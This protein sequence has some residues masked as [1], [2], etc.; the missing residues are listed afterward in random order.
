ME[1]A[2]ARKAQAEE[3]RKHAVSWCCDS[4]VA[5]STVGNKECQDELH[6]VGTGGTL[7]VTPDRCSLIYVSHVIM[8]LPLD[9]GPHD[10]TLTLKVVAGSCCCCCCCCCCRC[11][12]PRAPASGAPLPP[13]P[14]RTTAAGTTHPSHSRGTSLALVLAVTS[15]WTTG[16]P[17]SSAA[18]APGAPR[19]QPLA[20]ATSRRMS[21]LHGLMLPS[22]RVQVNTYVPE[23]AW[24]GEGTPPGQ[25]S[26]AAVT[27]SSNPGQSVSAPKQAMLW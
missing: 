4:N 23:G 14:S 3:Q 10:A 19:A 17:S 15:D 25:V 7:R 21:A 5:C 13:S 16:V 1:T 9:Q 6:V 12:H 2:A 27:C 26:Q 8:V 22:F 20:A 24:A 18:T 11:L